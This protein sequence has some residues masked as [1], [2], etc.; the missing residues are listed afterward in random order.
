MRDDA[1]AFIVCGLYIVFLAKHCR[2]V[3]CLGEGSGIRRLCN[4]RL[5][6]YGLVALRLTSKSF[7]QKASVRIWDYHPFL[8]AEF[9][10]QI[11]VF[12]SEFAVPISGP[13]FGLAFGSFVASSSKV[14]IVFLTLGARVAHFPVPKSEPDS[15]PKSATVFCQKI[16]GP[17]KKN[18]FAVRGLLG[19][20]RGR[21][22]WRKKKDSMIIFGVLRRC[23]LQACCRVFLACVG[24]RAA[25]PSQWRA[26]LVCDK[27]I[28]VF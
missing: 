17:R 19:A 6:L 8:V 11:S 26:L 5:F 10:V 4:R 15:G 21:Q 12:F 27:R 25:F 9:L 23:H 14:D 3:G 28:V 22:V 1:F 2:S 24:D 20:C 18:L 13:E 7:F 16:E